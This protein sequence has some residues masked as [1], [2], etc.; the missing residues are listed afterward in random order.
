MSSLRGDVYTSARRGYWNPFSLIRLLNSCWD[1]TVW[2]PQVRFRVVRPYPGYPFLNQHSPS[3]SSFL[4]M[5]ALTHLVLTVSIYK[6]RSLSIYAPPY[7]VFGW[8]KNKYLI[9][10]YLIV[11][12]LLW[13]IFSFRLYGEA[14][15]QSLL[16][17]DWRR[18]TPNR[19]EWK[20]NSDSKYP[21]L[22]CLQGI[23]VSVIYCNIFNNCHIIISNS[24][25]N[26]TKAE[27][28]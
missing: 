20:T 9:L 24:F 21:A 23:P 28:L 18:S 1:M 8:G 4:W 2:D 25:H 3:R 22:L 17:P 14:H 10:S 6:W 16:L 5:C 26:Q 27:T 12:Y 19:L 11:S 7:N 15:F 13:S